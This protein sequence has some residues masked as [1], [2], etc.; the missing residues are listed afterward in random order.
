MTPRCPRHQR[1][2]TWDQTY[3]E[4]RPIAGPE[5]AEESYRVTVF[6]CVARD[7]TETQEVVDR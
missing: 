6:A 1:P 5:G 7:C 3:I 4:S 2:M